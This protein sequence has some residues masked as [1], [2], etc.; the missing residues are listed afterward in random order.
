MPIVVVVAGIAACRAYG[1]YR[2]QNSS[3]QLQG[4]A[5]VDGGGG[6]GGDKEEDSELSRKLEKG[7]SASKK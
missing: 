6:N 7:D 1:E 5:A 3:A 2:R 4:L